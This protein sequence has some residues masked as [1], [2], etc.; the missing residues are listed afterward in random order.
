[1]FTDGSVLR[2]KPFSVGCEKPR[3]LADVLRHLETDPSLPSRPR[4][5]MCSALHSVCRVLGKEP[6]D[7]PADLRHLRVLLAKITPAAAG[8]C[9]GR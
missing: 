4:R 9:D 7:M 8:V 2:S 5:E 6:A 1:M 3:A